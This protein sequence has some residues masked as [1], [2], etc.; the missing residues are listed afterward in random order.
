MLYVNYISIKR[1]EKNNLSKFTEQVCGGPGIYTTFKTMSQNQNL[2]V[3]I[4]FIHWGL[5][6][7]LLIF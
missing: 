6:V 7:F 4:D 2:E 5:D 3:N 1:E